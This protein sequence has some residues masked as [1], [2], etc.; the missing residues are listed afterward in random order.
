MESATTE[1]QN[2]IM[3]TVEKY[4]KFIE[5]EQ[6][7][8]LTE[9]P[10]KKWF[11]VH[12]NK[13]NINGEEI[14][15][16]VTNI[17]DG[18]TRIRDK[19]G[20]TINLIGYDCKYVYIRD[21]ETNMTFN[22]FGEPVVQDVTDKKCRYYPAKTVIQGT[23]GELR[24]T[25]RVFCPK[26]EVAE[27]WT[28]KVENLSDRRRKVSVFGFAKFQLNGTSA[29]SG[30]IPAENFSEIIQDMGGV[31]VTNHARKETPTDRYKGYMITTS[32]EF[33]ATGYRDAFTR[34]DF[35][36][37]TP[38]I[39]WGWNCDGKCAGYDPDCSGIIQV[40]FDIP[41]KSSVR[42]DFIIGNAAS[43]KE[44][45][46]IRARLTPEAI[47][48]ACLEQEAIEK[49][50]IDAMTV[51]TGNKNYDGMIN[52]FSKTM[53]AAYLIDKSGFRD[54]VQID[55]AL[56]M[57]DYDLAKENLL[58]ALSSQYPNGSVPHGF[59]PMNRLT[60]ADKP[61][62]IF[63]T[64]PLMIKES[65]D[66]SLLDVVL[67][68]LDSDEEG[69]VWDHMVRAMKYLCN[70]TG[71]NGLCDQHFADWND[72]LEPS[73]LTG[74]RESVMVTQQLCYGLLEMEELAKRRGDKDVE[75]EA[76]TQF[77]KFK[78]LLNEFAWDG[79]WF[80]RTTCEHGTPLGTD[81]DDQAKIFMNTQ[82]W[83][84][85]SKTADGE[86][87]E[88]C[89]KSVDEYCELDIGFILCA[90]PCTRKDERIGKF[91]KIIPGHG[92]NGGAYCHASGFKGVADCMLGRAEEAWRTFKKIAPDSEW[93][94]ITNSFC[95]PFGFT[96]C[97]EAMPAQYGRGIYT[98]RT[99]TTGWFL[100]L[101]VEWIFGIRRTYEGLIVDPCM[102]VELDKVGLTRKFRG[103]TYNIEIDNTAGR[104]TGVTSIEVDGGKIEGN[105]LPVFDSGEHRVKVIV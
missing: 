72:G 10:P 74:E 84:V 90:P 64:V 88:Q 16:E 71:K 44:V 29:E 28:V 3:S 83:A 89:M 25:Q 19:D 96:N 59:R 78:K 45:K 42:T 1:N 104:K 30:G 50:R 105:L 32:K 52:I 97:Y 100:M 77:D 94:P 7:F 76:R 22:P 49:K 21:D 98:W 68:Y 20:N 6:C 61:A 92:T 101:L 36:L 54:N 82:S 75:T 2:N 18:S 14:Y 27:V 80:I 51:R 26:D 13:S 73:K 62:W 93:N 39:L 66:F 67:P 81:Q 65:G 55:A 37:S 8:E 47:D 9:T 34:S 31:F 12:Y 53:M 5:E 102:S 69:T 23:A 99:G 86:R 35:S 38:K 70:D 17:G 95:E 63:L 48:A 79:K 40:T 46:N 87:A 56:A 24:A 60:Y 41:P 58:R 103:A 91:S 57:I 33:K 4:G 15:S 85:L 11:N 43:P